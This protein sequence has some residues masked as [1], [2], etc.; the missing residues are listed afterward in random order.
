MCCFDADYLPYFSQGSVFSFHAFVC[1][2]ILISEKQGIERILT[3]PYSYKGEK[4]TK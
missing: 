2:L 4:F 3:L 1:S